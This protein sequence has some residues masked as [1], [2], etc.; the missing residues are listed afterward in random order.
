VTI[1]SS[2]FIILQLFHSNAT[3]IPQ[4]FPFF[5]KKLQIQ[6]PI[7]LTLAKN[8]GKVMLNAPS[9]GM[10]MRHLHE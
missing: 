4:Q 10:K 2:I 6:P 1:T 7:N 5:S 9:S 3:E 8:N